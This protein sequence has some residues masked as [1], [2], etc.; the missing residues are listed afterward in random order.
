MAVIV[1]LTCIFSTVR[2]ISGVKKNFPF[3]PPHGRELAVDEEITIFGNV[4]ESLSRSNDRFGTR[5]QDAFQETL[6]RDWLEIRNTPAPIFT[7]E[8]TT[9]DDAVKTLGI[10][11]GSVVVNDPCWESSIT[12]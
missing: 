4:L 5:D 7:D 11:T 10:N 8:V 1:D 12:I 3:L 2:N 6:K 9:G